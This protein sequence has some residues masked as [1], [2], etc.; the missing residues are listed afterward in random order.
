LLHSSFPS[1]SLSKLPTPLSS[2][3]M[4]FSVYLPNISS[5]SFQT[6]LL[7][8]RFLFSVAILFCVVF[9]FRS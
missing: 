8:P 5:L 1:I 4:Y 6:F 2:V 3:H 9:S 7:L